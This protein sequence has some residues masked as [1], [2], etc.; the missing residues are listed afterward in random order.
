MKT[1]EQKQSG[2]NGKSWLDVGIEHQRGNSHE[3]AVLAFTALL[4]EDPL[5]IEAL[6]RRGLSLRSLGF[7]DLS[8]EDF[9]T[10]KEASPSNDYLRINMHSSCLHRCY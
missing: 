7:F 10:V 1:D 8:A 9:M 5:H 4:D 2:D 6:F 3:D